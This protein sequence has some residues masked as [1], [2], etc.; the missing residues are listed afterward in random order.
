MVNRVGVGGIS[1]HLAHVFQEATGDFR[2]KSSIFDVLG[3]CFCK[4][5]RGAHVGI[6]KMCFGVMKSECAEHAV[7]V[8]PVTVLLAA[9][10][11]A[12]GAIAEKGALQIVRDCAFL[13]V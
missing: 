9:D 12:S 8:E 1:R 3:F 4:I 6:F 7:A 2:A 13:G 11:L 10:A 5:F